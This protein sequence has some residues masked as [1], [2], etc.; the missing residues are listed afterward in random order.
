[1]SIWRPFTQEKTAPNQVKIARG[2]GAYLLDEHG[3]R[4]LDLISSWWVNTLGHANEE[5]ADAI[6]FQARSLEHVIFAGFSHEPAE[7]L[8]SSLERL[9]P[10]QLRHFFFSDDGSTAVEV[11][12]K[13]AYQYFANQGVKNR[14]TYINLEGAYHGD[15][16]GAMGASGSNSSYHATFK[17]FFFN[18]YSVKFPGTLDDEESALFAL[19]TFLAKNG[20][21]VCSLIVE[22]LVQGAAGMRMY[23]AE[24]LEKVVA[25][26]RKYGILVIF[27]EVMTGF[28]RTGTMFA[29]NQTQVIPDFLCISK[30]ITGG[31]LPL[32]LTVSVDAV[33]EAFYSDEP[34]KAF[35]HGHSY[36]ANPIS[37]AAAVK[38][39]EILQR[40]NTQ[41]DIQRIAELHTK[42]LAHLSHVQNK[43]S[44]GTIAAFEVDS[45]ALAQEVASR[46]FDQGIFIRPIGN[47]IYFIPPYCI[48]S[49][50]LA[51]AYVQTAAALRS[52]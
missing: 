50:D 29:M 22:P 12:L 36:T 27:D 14:D 23:R 49:D 33:Y 48:S 5:I 43:R 31:F 8:C 47:T 24:F 6:A 34:S 30:G 35:L 2:E 1:M 15:T 18:T 16:F 39:L 52:M 41:R 37:C 44:L 42:H 38:S 32:G 25:D 20:D 13:M 9:L 19:R 46:L 7:A 45:A 11:A 26:V 21:K 3:K 51:R 17:S 4:Y 40:N 10:Q 28:F